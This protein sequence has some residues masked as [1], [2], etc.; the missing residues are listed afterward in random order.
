MIPAFPNQ[1]ELGPSLFALL[2]LGRTRMPHFPEARL[3]RGLIPSSLVI[4]LV[5]ACDYLCG[6]L[7]SIGQLVLE[8]NLGWPIADS[9]TSTGV[10]I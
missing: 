6:P 3:C 7:D 10:G 8:G 2:V 1:P 4:L 9:I 5:L